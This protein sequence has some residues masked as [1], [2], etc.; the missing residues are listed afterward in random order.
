[1]KKLFLFLLLAVF[2]SVTFAS[3]FDWNASSELMKALQDNQTALDPAVPARVQQFIDDATPRNDSEKRRVI[4]LRVMVRAQTKGSDMSWNA[5]KQFVDDQIA[6]AELE[7]E[8]AVAD[9][10]DLLYIWWYRG[11]DKEI[12]ELMKTLP[13]AEL[14]GNAGH[15][16]DKMGKYAEA[17]EYYKAS[18]IFPD[19][20]VNIAATRLNDPAKAFEA[21][22]LILTRTYNA[23]CV[24]AVIERVVSGLVGNAD[25][26]AD[27][28]K[29]FLQNANRKYSSMLIKEEE[30]W[31]PI[32]TTIRTMLET[33]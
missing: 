18:A 13:G 11:W 4:A 28:M 22:R 3:G 20:A 6:A 17:Y 21:A 30:A 2:A 26:P 12:Y 16:C 23:Q 29:A 10:L 32:I 15:I 8:I 27:E 14:W 24:S 31:K 33:Y 9:Y 25:I 19:R 7:K 5:Q 1:M